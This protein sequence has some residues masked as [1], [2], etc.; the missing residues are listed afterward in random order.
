MDYVYL[1]ILQ[2]IILANEYIWS[3]DRRNY[4]RYVPNLFFPVPDDPTFSQFHHETLIDGELV[5]DKESDGTVTLKLLTFDLLVIDKKNLM[6]RALTTRLG[7]LKDHIIKPY[8]IMLSKRPEYAEAQPFIIELKHME[9]SY[10]LD[11]VLDTVIPNLRHKND[12]LIFT[13]SIAGYKTG[14]CEKMIKWK[15]PNENSIDFLLRFEFNDDDDKPRFCLHKW[16]ANNE[17]AYFDDMYVTDDEWN[18]IWKHDYNRYEGKIVEVVH[19]PTM[20]PNVPWRFIRFRNDKQHANHQSVVEK[21]M[22]SI[23]DGITEEQLRSHITLIREAWKKRDESKN[24]TSKGKEEKRL[25]NGI[26]SKRLRDSHEDN[27]ENNKK[28]QRFGENTE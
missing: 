26:K 25:E 4:Y 17:H 9:F 16:I 18:E 8:E 27:Y 24:D 20:N 1:S 15:P 10:G 12:G 11:K 13:S 5:N 22:Q 2:V 3:I 19:D 23:I 14:T 6:K 28:K 21:I 7:Y